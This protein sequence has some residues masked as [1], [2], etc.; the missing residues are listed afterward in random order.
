LIL[1]VLNGTYLKN[2]SESAL[3]ID[4]YEDEIVNEPVILESEPYEADSF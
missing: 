1:G 2:N 3:S 4:E